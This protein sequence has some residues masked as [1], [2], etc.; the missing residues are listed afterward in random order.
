ML[1]LHFVLRAS[2][3]EQEH[4]A[5]RSYGQQI[6]VNIDTRVNY[7]ITYLSL[8]S[9][10]RVLLEAMENEEY[11]HVEARLG[12][13]TT[14]FMS[15]HSGRVRDIRLYLNGNLDSSDVMVNTKLIFDEFAPGKTAFRENYFLTGTYL[16]SRNEKIFSL[17][18]KVYQLNPEREYF[19]EMRV[20]ETEL[21]GFFNEDTSG[22]NIYILTDDYLTSMSDR[23]LFGPLLYRS[24]ENDSL[25]VSQNDVEML[26]DTITIPGGSSGF[27]VIVEP[28]PEYLDRGYRIMLFRLIPVIIFVLLSSLLF[29]FLISIN[30]KNRLKTLQGKIAAVSNW[31]L[32]TNLEIDGRDEFG[33][34]AE[35]LDDT[36]ERILDLIVQNND[37]NELKRVAEM[38]ALRAQINSHFLFNSLSSIKWLSRQ[39]NKE[40]LSDAV[41][42]LALFLRYSLVLDENQVPLHKELSQ[43][44]AYVYLQKLR[45]GDELHVHIDI[46]EELLSCK[47]VKLVLQP[48]VENSI[49]HGRR[50]DGKLL[51][52]TIYTYSDGEYYNLIVEDDGIGMSQEMIDN[53]YSGIEITSQSGCGLKNVI[54]RVK[55]CSDGLGD[56][57][58]ES[59]YGVCTKTTIRQPL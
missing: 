47:T 41:E 37:I 12:T 50:E 39:D 45:Y 25:S 57:I 8:L 24:R 31:E 56:V 10:D 1:M 27:D 17:F 42:K 35:E 48:L 44:E 19:L 20:Y 32:N 46:D 11:Q 6:S 40:V 33:L 2:Y 14:E 58:I 34:L 13:M 49:I 38:S 7:F 54:E 55:M 3:H 18:T 4:Q 23:N 26:A 43:L 59:Q 5:L 16:N 36:R 22:S 30:F 21:L 28:S 29:T 51:N 9:M 52:I 15:L 53:I